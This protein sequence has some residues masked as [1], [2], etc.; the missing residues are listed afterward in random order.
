MGWQSI[1]N[2]YFERRTIS[3]QKLTVEIKESEDLESLKHILNSKRLFIDD[4]IQNKYNYIEINGKIE[5]G[6]AYYEYGIKPSVSIENVRILWI[7][8]GKKIVAIDLYNG[9]I[10]LEKELSSIFYEL[11]LDTDQNYLCVICELNLYCFHHHQIL[12][13]IGFRDIICGFKIINNNK[14]EIVC[15]DGEEYL[16]ELNTGQFKN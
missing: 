3:L 16:F 11:L 9:N 1:T 12:W 2:S 13:E 7:G 5:C 4:E 15:N 10:I 14:I 8:F 6:M